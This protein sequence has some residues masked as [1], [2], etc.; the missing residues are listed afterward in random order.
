[1]LAEGR[2][3]S[4]PPREEEVRCRYCGERIVVAS[5]AWPYRYTQILTHL[6]LCAREESDEYR[7]DAARAMTKND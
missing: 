7:R 3:L 2:L 5:G 1:M 6:M 4:L